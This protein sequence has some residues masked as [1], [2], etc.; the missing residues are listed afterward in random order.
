[1]EKVKKLLDAAFNERRPE[2]AAEYVT[3]GYIQ[4]NPQVPT[5]KEG[6]L[7]A[8]PMFYQA[9]PMLSWQLKHIWADGDYVIVHSI[10]NFGKDNAVVDIFR[11]DG[12]QIDEHWDVVQEIPAKMAHNNGM[13]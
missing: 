6:L 1:M 11:F 4:H 5:G 2:W 10:Y 9:F 8:L 13:F 3:D 7:E 12:D